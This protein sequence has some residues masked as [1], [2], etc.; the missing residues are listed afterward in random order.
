LDWG[1][2]KLRILK[3]RLSGVRTTAS[4]GGWIVMMERERRYLGGSERIQNAL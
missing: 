4:K 2:K 3:V 1:G